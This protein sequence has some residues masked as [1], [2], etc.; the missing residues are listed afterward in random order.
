[1]PELV[2]QLISTVDDDDHHTYILVLMRLCAKIE[3]THLSII[4]L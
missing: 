1:M 2:L 4:F 3:Y